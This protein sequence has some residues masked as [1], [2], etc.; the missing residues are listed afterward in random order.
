MYSLTAKN[1]LA[2]HHMLLTICLFGIIVG[3][4]GCASSP[5]EPNASAK[6]ILSQ[7]LITSATLTPQSHASTIVENAQHELVAAWFG[8][9]YERHPDVKIYI[10]HFRNN[11]WS[12][13][14]AVADGKQPDGLS[15]PTWNPV[16]FQP[17]GGD[18]ILFYKV[19]PNPREWWG[20]MMRSSD[21]GKTWQTP[22]RLPDGILGPIKNKAIVTSMGTWLA[23]SSTEDN[24]EWRL[25]FEMSKD[26]GRTWSKTEAIDPGPGLNA[27]Q[28]SAITHADGRLQTLARTKQGVI[29]SSWSSD[30][31]QTWSP[32]YALALPNPNSGTDAVTLQDGR[33]LLVYNPSAH[34]PNTPG[35]GVRYPLA[36]AISN[37][38]LSWRD[39]LTL[40]DK[41]IVEGYAYPAVIQSADGLVHITYTVG[42]V[43]IKHMVIDPARLN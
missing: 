26:K 29:A 5:P 11:Q 34:Q 40:E 30:R 14:V 41:P 13:P 12:T 33:Q 22:E 32:L 31:G 17:P 39:V 8:G 42:R 23:P 9:E 19:G 35:K 37:D 20:M 28:P 6:A 27:I 43:H 1:T 4:S 3:L 24:D 38:G 10:A 21:G 15:L 18:L 36:L 16:L 25:H 7:Q 2:R